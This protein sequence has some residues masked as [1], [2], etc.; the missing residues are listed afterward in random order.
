MSS[1]SRFAGLAAF[2]ATAGFA[3]VQVAGRA[4]GPPPA[5]SVSYPIS[6]PLERAFDGGPRAILMLAALFA[7]GAIA[8]GLHPRRAWL[9]GFASVALFPVAIAVELARDSTSH[10]LF[11]FELV[12]HAMLALPAVLGAVLAAALRR[13]MEVPFASLPSEETR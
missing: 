5:S 8:G 6:W 12:M 7:V 4:S 11:P 9:L 1:P 13:R 3:I 10:N 2:T